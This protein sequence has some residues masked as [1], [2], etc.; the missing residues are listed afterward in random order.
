MPW[1][2]S[3]GILQNRLFLR[4]KSAHFRQSVPFSLL[5]HI[6]QATISMDIDLRPRIWSTPAAAAE[7]H[8]WPIRASRVLGRPAS[9]NGR[10][11]MLQRNPLQP[12]RPCVPPAV[13]AE[14]RPAGICGFVSAEDFDATGVLPGVDPCESHYWWMP[15]LYGPEAAA[16]AES[17]GRD[18]A[19]RRTASRATAAA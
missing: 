16:G 18:Q 14:A 2:F 5:A 4:R 6:P 17:A 1:S 12:P 15:E 11:N 8:S 13:A 3:D 10:F 7:R 9:T 19:T